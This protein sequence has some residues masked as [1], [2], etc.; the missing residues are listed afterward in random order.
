M[1]PRFTHKCDSFINL[2]IKTEYEFLTTLIPEEKEAY[3]L[4][5]VADERLEYTG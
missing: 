4:N 1:A 5:H 2:K 3:Q